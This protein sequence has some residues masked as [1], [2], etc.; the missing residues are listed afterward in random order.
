MITVWDIVLLHLCCI[1]VVVITQ[2]LH[3]VV[4]VST[5]QSSMLSSQTLSTTQ[6]KYRHLCSH[7]PYI[8]NKAICPQEPTLSVAVSWMRSSAET[9]SDC[10]THQERQQSSIFKGYLTLEYNLPIKLFFLKTCGIHS[11]QS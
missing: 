8:H 2:S 6:T 5:L 7:S 10:F 9:C 11:A 3:S 1:Q 4:V